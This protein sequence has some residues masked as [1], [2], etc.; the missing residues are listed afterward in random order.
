MIFTFL[1]FRTLFNIIIIL[2]ENINYPILHKKAMPQTFF[3][4]FPTGIKYIN[5][6]IGV[7]TINNFVYYFNGNMPIYH[8]HK[9]D[10]RSFR[11][12]SSQMVEL[13]NVKQVE[14]VKTF[15][16]S[17]ESVKRWVKVYRTKGATGFFETRK[18]KKKGSVLNDDLLR[19]I[20]SE[21]NLGTTLGTIGQIHGIKPDTIRKA[22]KSGRLTKPEI[23]EDSEQQKEKTKS[24]RNQEDSK[25]ILGMGCI[26]T[27]G[28]MDAIVK[29]K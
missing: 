8:H 28:R 11:Y 27:S 24:Q 6:R 2:Q 22:I 13:G 5:S 12:I 14:I 20:Q 17:K 4:V 29:K 7:K 3:P 26:N 21:L 19:K 25:A 16:V 23:S 1:V 18:G 15:E 10:Y 9:D